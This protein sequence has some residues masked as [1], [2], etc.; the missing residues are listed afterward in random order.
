MKGLDRLMAPMKRRI[1]L[2]IGRAVVR[3][4][5]DGMKMQT[6]QISLLD[7]EVRANVERFQNYGFTSHPKP[8]AEAIAASVMGNRDHC[9]VLAV[10]D[11]RYRLQ[12][13]EAGE[14][15][16]YDDL[17]QKVHLTRTG[18][19]IDGAGLPVTVTNTPEIV[20]DTPLV[21]VTGDVVASGISLVNHVHG[22]VAVG[23][24][25]TAAPQ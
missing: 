12:G 16:L 20:L 24:S 17:G 10:D 6:L 15:A 9:V 7:G 22:G 19:V 4:V 14:V 3:L 5:N 8:G 1:L 13:L 25:A 21:T 18:I 2:M 23:S 11:R